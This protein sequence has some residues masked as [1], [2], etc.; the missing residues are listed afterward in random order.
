MVTGCG[1][2][3]RYDGR[4][5]Q[6]D[7]LMWA[8]ADSA[9]AVL[10]ALDTLRGAA[11]SAYRDLLLTQ[12]RYK[13]YQDITAR[14]DS[15]ITR[16]LHWYRAHNG[17]REKL[18]RAN[19]YKG[20]VMEEL[21]HVDSAMIYYKTAEAAA[22]TT[23]YANLGQINTRIADLFRL[24]DCSE[25]ICFD[26]YK[27]AFKYH[28]LTGNKMMQLM[29]LCR[30]YMMNAIVK[31][32]DKDKL[33]EQAL[34]LA[35]ELGNDEM[36]FYILEL[37]CRSLMKV[38]S[39][40]PEAKQI[41][42]YCMKEG[43]EYI[44]N[45][46]LLDFAYIYAKGY[47]TDS[48]RRFIS[49]VDVAANEFVDQARVSARKNDILCMIAQ[50]EGLESVSARHIAQSGRLSDSIM[51]NADRFGI[52]KIES[53][54]N[55]S[56]RQEDLSKINDLNWTLILLSLGAAAVIVAMAVT[57]VIR[58]IRVRK[59]IKALRCANSHEH[60]RILSQ[61]DDQSSITGRLLANMI[62]LIK[63]LA[64]NQSHVS[65]TRVADQIKETIVD[66]ANDDF[67]T[68]LRSYLDKNYSGLM[69]DLEREY[70]L[71]EKEMKFIELV[72]CGFSAAEMAIILDYSPKY[73]FTKRKRIAL[74]M[75]LSTTL[76]DYLNNL[77]S[78][79]SSESSYRQ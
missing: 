45:D 63:S 75:G 61:L 55:D 65:A 23:D 71:N 51:N 21:G 59:Q 41:A 1:G 74:K 68:E 72:C 9:L 19:L 50:L 17:E 40:L 43:S 70:H 77:K 60:D 76:Q 14:D 29:N 52:E 46:L 16:A 27:T 33:F 28:Q 31:R 12:A 69:T 64:D 25:Q 3:A 22:D 32:Y 49:L 37:K 6:A 4:L 13:T 26:K 78:G 7:S 30:M 67:W 58:F 18:T 34:S 66:V 38:D 5:V 24:N 36:K 15:A 44:G 42:Q 2:R 48:A 35:N 79:R 39:S 56:R 53:G 73:V 54:F 8:D 20:A 10:S 57:F 62:I 11:D 47:D